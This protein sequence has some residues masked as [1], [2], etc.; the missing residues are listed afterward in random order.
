MG[1]EAI[2]YGMI[3]GARY[4]FGDRFRELHE[5]NAVEIGRLP[6]EDPWPWLVRGHFAL[7]AAYPEGLYRTQVIRVGLSMKDDPGDTAVWDLWLSKLEAVLRRLYWV[8]T[9]VHVQTELPKTTRSYVWDPTEA[10]LAGMYADD[11]QPIASW[12]RRQI[13][14]V[15]DG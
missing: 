8:R 2:V 3:Q 6:E 4:R 12:A 15:D 10:A 5:R 7:P 11:P 13:R 1:H 9:I 14:I